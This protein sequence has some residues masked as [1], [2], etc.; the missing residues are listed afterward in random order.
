MFSMCGQGDQPDLGRGGQSPVVDDGL[1]WGDLFRDQLCLRC[2]GPES[3]STDSLPL[4]D[5][6]MRVDKTRKRNDVLF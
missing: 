3:D 4:V 2:P 6:H 1:A 5:C